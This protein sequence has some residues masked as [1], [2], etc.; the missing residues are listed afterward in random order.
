MKF[1]AHIARH[2]ATALVVMANVAPAAATQN[3]PGGAVKLVIA[4][5]P[6]GTTDLLARIL[7][8]KS[9][10]VLGQSVMIENKPGA[11]TTLG[12]NYVAKSRP[13]GCTVLTLT[14][15]G[16]VASVYRDKLPYN[17]NTDFVP[18]S[19]VGSFPMV[20]AVSTGS[21][22]RNFQDVV[23]AIKSKDGIVYGSGGPG[24]LGH[25]ST[26]RLIGDLGGR[27]NHIPYKGNSE[28]M[29]AL[30]ADHVQLFFPSAAE[31]LPLATDGKI[32]LIAVT[33]AERLS[34]LPDIPTTKELGYPEFNPR[35]WY[36]FVVPTGTPEAD[37]TRLREAFMAAANDPTV[38]ERFASLGFASEVGGGQALADHIKREAARWSKIIDDN[39]LRAAQ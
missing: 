38:K 21:N 28:A 32:R 27:G 34:A 37:V 30:M 9:R 13:D 25:L 11:T 35:L 16:V 19:S 29:H 33:A 10:A 6:G 15:A 26:V 17:L 2:V 36:G 24:S 20:I 3:C 1:H 31:A 22:L 5:P 4:N 7:A 23:A 12:A 39:N 14:A 8:D 18:V